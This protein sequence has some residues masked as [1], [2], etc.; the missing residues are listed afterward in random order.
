MTVNIKQLL[1]KMNFAFEDELYVHKDT[2]IPLTVYWN[3]EKDEMVL[4]DQLKLPYEMTHWSTTDY[5][6]G[7][8]Q[9]IKEMRIRGSQAL[10][11]CAAYCMVLAAK[12]LQSTGREMIRN[13]EEAAK[14][15]K[16]SRPTA[17]PLFWAVDLTMHSAIKAFNTTADVHSVVN[18]VKETANY[19]LAS[20]LIL[21]NYLRE[22]GMKYLE[23]GDVIMTHCNGGSLSSTYGGHAL[24]MLEEAYTKGVD[25][26]VVAKE[27]RPRSQGYLLTTWELN[28]AG[29]PVVIVTDNMISQAFKR[30]KI[31]KIILG[32]DRIGSDGGVANKIGSSDIARIARFYDDVH[33]YYATSYSTMDL[34][35]PGSEIPIEE[36][37]IDEITRPYRLDAQDKKGR[38]ILSETALN[39]WP[40]NEAIVTTPQKGKFVLYNPAFDITPGNLIDLIITDIGAFSPEQIRTLTPAIVENKVKRRLETELTL[41]EHI[42]F[43][44]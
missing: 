28:K 25:L 15:V 2:K 29:V 40:P 18:A 1:F 16:S 8:I 30:F 10:G 44:L 23:D 26:T 36:R 3:E 37:S 32:V 35:T 11:V 38:G 20:D 19:I 43:Y 4:L 6:V 13:M 9:G 21:G 33:F 41:P 17:A 7:A 31:N 42:R 39:E 14:F 27:T 22:E 34:E 5:K 12:Q 24:G